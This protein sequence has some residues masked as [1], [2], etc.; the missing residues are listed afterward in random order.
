MT[1]R[2]LH[3]NHVILFARRLIL[4]HK[5][6]HKSKL[7][8]LFNYLKSFEKGGSLILSLSANCRILFLFLTHNLFVKI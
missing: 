7:L 2:T 6:I 4:S 3:L 5:I 1:R 8:L